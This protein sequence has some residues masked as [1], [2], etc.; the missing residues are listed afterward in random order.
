MAIFQLLNVLFKGANIETKPI[1]DLIP[2]HWASRSGDVV[3]Y[4][5]F[6]GANKNVKNRDG[7]TP[8]DLADNDEMRNIL[9]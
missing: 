5:V 6:K 7:V 2:L 3:K 4:L 1:N 9:K 8:Y